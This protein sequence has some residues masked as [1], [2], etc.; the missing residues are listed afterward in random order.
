MARIFRSELET[1]ARHQASFAQLETGGELFG[2][3]THAGE[4]VI[5]VATGPGKN[6]RHHGTS[7]YQDAE[8]LEACHHEAHGHGLVHL[9][10]W[11]SHHH[12]GLAQPSGGDLATARD[13]LRSYGWPG[14]VMAIGNFPRHGEDMVEFGFY[15]VD[16]KT[17]ECR[18][19]KVDVIDRAGAFRRFRLPP[20][21]ADR[22]IAPLVALRE[23]RPGMARAT[24]MPEHLPWYMDGSTKK[25]I[26]RDTLRLQS[27]SADGIEATLRP[28][29][30]VLLCDARRQ[31]RR[32]QLML[33]RGYP[34]VPPTLLKPRL[35]PLAWSG[36]EGDLAT[37][38]L[39]LCAPMPEIPSDPTQPAVPRAIH[40]QRG[41]QP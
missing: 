18:D 29:G 4:P 3:W 14:F 41:T 20:G 12:I 27:L 15:L 34:Q 9:G 35:Q 28:D 23:P 13:A 31:D 25:R 22:G 37:L 10:A 6:A 30:D 17:G 36:E 16:G 8:F 2:L 21:T 11:H 19:L 1:M 24:P 5:F 32:V 33:K 40:E 38:V 26:V 7:F 39:G